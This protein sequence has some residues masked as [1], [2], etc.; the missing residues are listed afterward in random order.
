MHLST[1]RFENGRFQNG[2][3]REWFFRFRNKKEFS[4]EFS[5]SVKDN[6][7]KEREYRFFK[8]AESG[9]IEY[10]EEIHIQGQDTDLTK[11]IFDPIKLE[12]EKVDE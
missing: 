4:K 10:H 12:W 9:N 7:E 8:D 6:E 2:N 5:K 11:Y 1:Y 3:Y